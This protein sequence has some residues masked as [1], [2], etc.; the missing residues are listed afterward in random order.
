MRSNWIELLLWLCIRL[1]LLNGVR[2]RTWIELLLWPCI[3]LHVLC[4]IRRRT[5]LLL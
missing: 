5:C 3:R 2:C 4:G 1:C